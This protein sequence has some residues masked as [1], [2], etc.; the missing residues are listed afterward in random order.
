MD[1]DPDPLVRG[2][3]PGI[4]IRTKMSRISNTDFFFMIEGSVPRT[5]GSGS[6]PGSPTLAPSVLTFISKFI[7][8]ES[9]RIARQAVERAGL[10]S[11]NEYATHLLLQRPEL[12][13]ERLQAEE[14]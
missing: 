1:S 2:T 7:L 5:N 12:R 4:R 8:S 14:T 13:Q 6:V 3:D 10:T 11:I 9:P